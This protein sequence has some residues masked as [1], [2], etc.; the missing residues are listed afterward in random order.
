[1]FE[2]PEMIDG[3]VR[4]AVLSVLGLALIIAIVRIV[5]LRSFSKMTSFDFVITLATGSLL[6]S[7]ATVSSW[8]D[9]FQTAVAIAVL[10]GLQVLIARTRD[11]RNKVSDY[12]LNTPSLLMKDGE[13]IDETMN[14]CR[15]SRDDVLAK[16]R[17]ANVKTFEDVRAVVLETTGDISVLHGSDVDPRLLDDVEQRRRFDA[18]AHDRQARATRR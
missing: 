8:T 3:I 13:F 9:A 15:V 10:M 14:D 1:M 17:Q 2:L 18:F 7:I 6:A 16:L 11:R 12:L 4:G 5:G